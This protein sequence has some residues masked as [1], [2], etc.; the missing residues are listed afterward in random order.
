M[1]Q[2][3]DILLD[4]L[5]PNEGQNSIKTETLSISV[6]RVTANELG[7]GENTLEK[8]R[9]KPPSGDA[10]GLGESKYERNIFVICLSTKII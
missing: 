5:V 6:E 2:L 8:C 1:G 4:Y 10:F 3:Q 9:F 7:N